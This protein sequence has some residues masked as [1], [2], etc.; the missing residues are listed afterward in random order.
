MGPEKWFVKSASGL[1]P[2][3]EG[4]QVV[5]KLSECLECTSQSVHCS[6]V[7]CKF[8]CLHMYE[9]DSRCFDYTNGH[10][11]CK[12]IHRVHSIKRDTL[13]E[14]HD[15]DSSQVIFHCPEPQDTPGSYTTSCSEGGGIPLKCR[16]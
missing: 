4:Y 10:I 6:A 14:N 1:L 16:Y 8:L 11:I 2:E 15:T 13:H 5:K 7:E 12:H 3:S 9:C